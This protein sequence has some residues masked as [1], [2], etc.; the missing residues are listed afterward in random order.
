MIYKEDIINNDNSYIQ[1]SN[2]KL[3]PE[4]VYNEN[5]DKKV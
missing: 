1:N 2:L 3:K 5:L 4:N